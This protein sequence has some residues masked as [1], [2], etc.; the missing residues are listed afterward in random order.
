MAPETVQQTLQSYGANA[1]KLMSELVLPSSKGLIK[2]IWQPP[3]QQDPSIKTKI[4][5]QKAHCK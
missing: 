1:A 5:T 4:V 3:V 2:H